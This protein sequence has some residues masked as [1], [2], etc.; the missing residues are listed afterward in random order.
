MLVDWALRRVL[1]LWHLVPAM[2][3]ITPNVRASAFAAAARRSATAPAWS[4]FR[5]RDIFGSC[6]NTLHHP[7]LDFHGIE[8]FYSLMG[9][10]CTS[11]TC[12]GT[13]QAIVTTGVWKDGRVATYR[14]IRPGGGAAVFGGTVLGDKGVATVRDG[15]EDEVLMREL[16]E[17]SQ[18]T[19]AA[20][21]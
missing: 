19:P 12:V 10:G 16:V 21:R 1:V 9:P 2:C 4:P 13:P 15:G 7:E 6:Q 17:K 8:M 11:V 14:G 20:G 18:G 5:G 3:V